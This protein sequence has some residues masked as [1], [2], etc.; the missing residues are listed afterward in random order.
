MKAYHEGKAPRVTWNE[1]RS[2]YLDGDCAGLKEHTNLAIIHDK[3]HIKWTPCGQV[4]SS[5]ASANVFL[6]VFHTTDD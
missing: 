5:P 2:A 3:I 1:F 4:N 6:H